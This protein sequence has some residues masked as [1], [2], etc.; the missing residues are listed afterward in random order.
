MSLVCVSIMFL[1]AVAKY[2]MRHNLRQR[3]VMIIQVSENIVGMAWS[4][5]APSM[6][7]KACGRTCSHTEGQTESLG[8]T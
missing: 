7:A 4:R 8:L 2:L 1:P 3:R 5:V 6:T